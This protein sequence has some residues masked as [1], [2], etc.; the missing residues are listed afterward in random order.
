MCRKPLVER[1]RITAAHVPASVPKHRE[2][3]YTITTAYTLVECENGHRM[4][5]TD[6]GNDGRFR[7]LAGT[8]ERGL[9]NA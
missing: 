6:K 8:K 9:W 1:E 3:P 2:Q 5:A 4:R 7:S